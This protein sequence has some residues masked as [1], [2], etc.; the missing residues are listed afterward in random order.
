MNMDPMLKELQLRKPSASTSGLKK[1][2][3]GK[4]PLERMYQLVELSRRVR[5][6][7]RLAYGYE[8]GA[9]RVG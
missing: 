3:A 5:E 6:M 1:P 7:K 2:A 9:R 8:V 4:T